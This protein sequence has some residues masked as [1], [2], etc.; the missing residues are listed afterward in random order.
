LP[1]AIRAAAPPRSAGSK[2]LF[3]AAAAPFTNNATRRRGAE[4][5][6]VLFYGFWMS[7]VKIISLIF[8]LRSAEVT[9][10]G[11]E[12]TFS[13]MKNILA[14]TRVCDGL[15]VRPGVVGVDDGRMTAKAVM[16]CLNE[17]RT[18]A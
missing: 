1:R 16:S 4:K 17:M 12:N 8:G 3:S 7:S 18:C 9:F 6:I 15:A 10:S 11:C 5:R 2:D 14:K 13:E